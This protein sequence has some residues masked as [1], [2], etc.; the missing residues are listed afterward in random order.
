M[1]PSQGSFQLAQATAPGGEREG[2]TITKGS[3]NIAIPPDAVG[4]KSREW[5]IEEGNTPETAGDRKGFSLIN[6]GYAK[7]CPTSE[8]IVEGDYEF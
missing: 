3:V 7:K 2:Y 5:R 6:G 4:M 8:G 1:G